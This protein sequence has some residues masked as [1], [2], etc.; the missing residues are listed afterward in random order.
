MAK[1]LHIGGKLLAYSRLPHMNGYR[2][3]A[4]LFFYSLQPVSPYAYGFGP[5]QLFPIS[6][7]S[8]LQGHLQ[9]FFGVIYLGNGLSF[10]A[11]VSRAERM[12]CPAFHFSRY[13]IGKSYINTAMAAA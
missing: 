1:S 8:F 10:R 7:G 13:A 3:G 9:P 4:I 11:D 5:A 6:L 2:L 12:I